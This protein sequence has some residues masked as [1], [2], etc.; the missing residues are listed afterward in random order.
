MRV[1]VITPL[2]NAMKHI[3]SLI[4]GIRTNSIIDYNVLFIDSS[5]TDS[6][7]TSLE[8]AKLD[9][10]IISRC[11]FDHGSTRQ[12]GVDLRPADIYVFLTQDSILA[13]SDSI[14]NIVDC[15]KDPSVGVAYGRQLPHKNANPIAAHHRLFN[16]PDKSYIRSF[17]DRY[18][19]GI[20]TCFNSNSFSA[21]R[22]SA[23]KEIGG[24]PVKNIV[25]ED[26]VVVAK[27]LKLGWKVNYCSS[28]KV[29]HSHN[30]TIMQEFKRYFDIGVF[31]K[32]Q[33]WL[34]E[35]FNSPNKEGFKF[36]KSEFG[37][38]LK[39]KKYY[40][41]LKSIFVNLFKFLGYKLGCNYCKI[42]NFLRLK[43]SMHKGFWVSPK[44]LKP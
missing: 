30:Y 25:G 33:N 6:T 20:K 19:Y 43:F 36:I 12:L 28:S 16:Y 8:E 9:Y 41:I 35:D 34:V 1:C 27:M 3:D 13:N 15:F 24:F 31:H 18:K 40:W 11:D 38:L 2:L 32:R 42:P 14:K 37:Y 26:V 5:S 10:H 21:Y 22:A 39:N 23:L 17:D 7:I 44:A 4:S 29:Y